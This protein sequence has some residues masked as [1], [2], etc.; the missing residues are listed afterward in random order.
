[1]PVRPDPFAVPQAA[2]ADPQVAWADEVWTWGGFIYGPLSWGGPGPPWGRR[3]TES[4][5]REMAEGAVT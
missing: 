2:W 3:G 1:M 5:R 4:E